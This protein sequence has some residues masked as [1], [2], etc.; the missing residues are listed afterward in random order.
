MPR[1]PG[2][3]LEQGCGEAPKRVG[4]CERH[5]QAYEVARG[6]STARGYDAKHERTRAR[7]L[8][9]AYG[10]RCVLCGKVMLPGQPLDLHHSIPLAQDRTARGDMIVHRDCN[11]RE[12]H[13][14]EARP[15]R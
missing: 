5:A 6:G 14:M 2:T 4:R 10:R 12:W 9:A 8:P 1:A 15:I 3:C 11:I 13:R 7:L